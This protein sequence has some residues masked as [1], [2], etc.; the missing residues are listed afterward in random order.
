M[1]EAIAHTNITPKIIT[2]TGY[3]KNGFL[4]PTPP[5]NEAK[6]TTR[7][8]TKQNAANA[9]KM[10]RK[11]MK[12]L[13]VLFGNSNIDGRLDMYEIMKDRGFLPVI[14]DNHVM[15]Y[16][17]FH[18]YYMKARK[19]RGLAKHRGTKKEFIEAHYKTWDVG[20]IADHIGSKIIYVQQT[21]SKIKRG[22]K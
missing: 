16:S 14:A 11:L 19:A 13:Y 22:V 4:T 2:P 5:N 21:I 12:G 8:I 17:R 10:N 9:E 15:S 20:A 7:A 18:H 1:R 3:I 6:E